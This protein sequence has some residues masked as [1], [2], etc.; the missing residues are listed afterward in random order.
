MSAEVPT[1]R[2]W[3]PSMATAS[4]S[5]CCGFSVQI[6]PLSRI[7]VAE[8]PH[9]PPDPSVARRATAQTNELRTFQLQRALRD[10]QHSRWASP[11]GL[12]RV[13]AHT[14]AISCQAHELTQ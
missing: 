12:P 3:L 7:S 6:L 13:W 10:R 8:R 5:G 9:T 14:G 4:D 2:I 11:V 1:E